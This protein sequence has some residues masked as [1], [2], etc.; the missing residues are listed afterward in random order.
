MYLVEIFL[1]RQIFELP[2]AQGKNTAKTQIFFKFIQALEFYLLS[3]N[4]HYYYLYERSVKFG[5]H[6]LAKTVKKI[7]QQMEKKPQA[8]SIP[9][10]LPKRMKP[11]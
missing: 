7:K 4:D 11:A 6:Y 8:L 10:T 9:H 2:N 1:N 5:Q 3:S